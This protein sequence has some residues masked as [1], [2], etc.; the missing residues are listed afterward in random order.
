MPN[1]ARRI[2]VVD[3]LPINRELLEDMLVPLGYQV[4]QAPDG[5]TALQ[6]VREISPDVILM[7]IMMPRMDGFEAARRLKQDEETK[8]IPI[9]MV[10]ALQAVGDRIKALEAGANDFLSKPVDR[11]ELQATVNSQ[12]QVKAYH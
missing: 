2:L 12:V 6:M 3:D 11:S 9:V 1:Q 10:T 7:D 8:A 4:F 5:E